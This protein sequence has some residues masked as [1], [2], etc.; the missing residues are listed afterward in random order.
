MGIQ[1]TACLMA[2]RILIETEQEY[3]FVRRRGYEPLLPNRFFKMEINLRRRIQSRLFGHSESGRGKDTQ[4]ANERFFRWIWEHKGHYC[5]ECMKPLREY[6]AVYCSHIKTRGSH[7]E[8]SIDP[9]NIN[10]LCFDH[11]NKWENG[12]KEDMRI[13]ES[14][15]LIIQELIEDYAKT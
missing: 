5:E 14:N 1:K 8:M 10:I 13:Y 15:Q 12:K 2:N 9:R 4:A 7:P 6:S 11:H 3:E